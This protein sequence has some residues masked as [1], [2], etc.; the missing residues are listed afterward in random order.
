MSQNWLRI[1]TGI[2]GN[3]VLGKGRL[4]TNNRASIALRI[5][6]STLRVSNTYLGA[7]F[8]RFRTK[9][10]APVAIKAM[11]AKLARLV[12][13]MLRYGMKICGPGSQGSTTPNT[14]GDRSDSSNVSPPFGFRSASLALPTSWP[15]MPSADF[16]SAVRL[17]LD[18]FS[19]RSDTEQISWGKLGRLL[20]T[21]AESTFRTLDGY[22]LRGTLPARPALTPYIR[23]LFIDSHTCSMLLSDPTS[24]R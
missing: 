20:C 22:G 23:F 15:N 16:C 11:A 24:R 5:A 7:Q 8:R 2:S 18:N 13:H 9:L 19:H 1:G 4:P 12:Y 10:G 17:P 3:K 14:A 21:V 6:A